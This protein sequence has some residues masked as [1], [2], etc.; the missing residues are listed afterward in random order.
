MDGFYLGYSL[1]ETAE[2]VRARHGHRVARSTIAAWLAEHRS[3]TTYT[4]LRAE[5]RRL[6]PPRQAIRICWLVVCCFPHTRVR[7]SAE[8]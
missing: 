3:L 8:E 1:D 2:K 4:R 5:G 7:L 6:Y